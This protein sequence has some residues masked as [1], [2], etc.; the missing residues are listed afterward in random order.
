MNLTKDDKKSLR[1]AMMHLEQNEIDSKEYCGG[2]YCGNKDVFLK[3]HAKAKA[4][5]RLLLT[6]TG[7][8]S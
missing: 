8:K 4:L 6:H 7:G 3:R 5:I 2:W 1:H